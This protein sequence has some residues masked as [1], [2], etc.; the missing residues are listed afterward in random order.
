MEREKGK[1]LEGIELLTLDRSSLL[2]GL[3][4][5][6]GTLFS[7]IQKVSG[8]RPKEVILLGCELE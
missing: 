6:I 7:K 3:V 1:K 4:E 5:E 8:G 2:L